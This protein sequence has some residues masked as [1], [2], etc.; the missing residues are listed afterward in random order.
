MSNLI[1][2]PSS[3]IREDKL[4]VH[5]AGKFHEEKLVLSKER[6]ALL[7]IELHKF[8]NLNKDKADE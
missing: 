2:A 7:Y 5:G 3:T 1:Y 4:I 6:A 8:L